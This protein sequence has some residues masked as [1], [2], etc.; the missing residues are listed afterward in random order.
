VEPA[1]GAFFVEL[2]GVLDGEKVLD[3]GCGTGSLAAALARVTGASN[4]RRR[5]RCAVSF[6]KKNMDKLS[7]F[8]QSDETKGSPL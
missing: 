3:L 1:A 7:R 2:V 8:I 5:E 6:L 4:T